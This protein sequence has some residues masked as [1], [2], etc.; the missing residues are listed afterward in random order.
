[1]PHPWHHISPTAKN[2]PD[3]VMGIIEV[4]S[5]SKAKYELHKET[6]LI[7]LDRMLYAAMH[8]P[9]NYGFIPQSYCDDKDP[10]DILVIS[11]ASLVPL[12]VVESV[13]IG[14]MRM[15][16][17]GETDDKIIAVAA[18]DPMFQ[19]IRE[20]SELPPPF[21]SELRHF[22]EYYK[23]LEKK[24]VKV[25]DF[26]SRSVAMQIIQESFDLYRETFGATSEYKT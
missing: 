8:Y 6:G 5:G 26:Q 3:A 19:H 2:N 18:G 11:Q 7:T 17:R 9:A 14:V 1:M 4:P 12:C 16:D 21:I 15:L 10:L 23:K 13:P 25:E 20:I 22:F 24:E